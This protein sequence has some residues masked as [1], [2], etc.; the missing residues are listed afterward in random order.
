MKPRCSSRSSAAEAAP[1]SIARDSRSSPTTPRLS[2]AARSRGRRPSARRRL[3]CRVGRQRQLVA[4]RERVRRQ[5]GVGARA[6]RRCRGRRRRRRRHQHRAPARR[7]P[8]RCGRCGGALAARSRRLTRVSWRA[9]PQVGARPQAPARR[10]RRR[11]LE[12]RRATVCRW[13]RACNAVAWKRS[14]STCW[15]GLAP[16]RR[17]RTGTAPRRAAAACRAAAG[18]S[19]AAIA[20]G[21]VPPR[22][23]IALVEL[24]D[25][26]RRRQRGARVATEGGDE[27][28]A[29]QRAGRPPP[30]RRCPR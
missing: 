1:C 12:Q 9:L 24:G 11:R 4:Q 13:R 15:S 18:T 25:E 2:K 10:R 17:P 16:A 27:A 30:P 28:G 29:M 8:G 3:H 22:A 14:S 26:A 6:R 21:A 5:P 7:S 19:A 23:P 20:G